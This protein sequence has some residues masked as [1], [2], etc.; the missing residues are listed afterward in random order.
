M[1]RDRRHDWYAPDDTED[2]H[3]DDKSSSSDDI[4]NATRYLPTSSDSVK[5]K[6]LGVASPVLTNRSCRTLI[7]REIQDRK[8]DEPYYKELKDEVARELDHTITLKSG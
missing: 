8:N 7:F 3:L 4:A 1:C 2:E 6:A 5:Q